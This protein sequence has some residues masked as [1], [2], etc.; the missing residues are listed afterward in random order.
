VTPLVMEDEHKDSGEQR[1][2]GVG[3][4][5]DIVGLIAFTLRTDDLRMISMRPANK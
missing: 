4:L 5:Q 1:F 2:R 3:Q